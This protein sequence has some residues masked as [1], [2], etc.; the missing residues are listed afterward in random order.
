MR[1]AI[2]ILLWIT[3]CL[4]PPHV[5]AES[6][7]SAPE[8]AESAPEREPADQDTQEIL[9]KVGDIEFTQCLLNSHGRERQV[10]CAYLSVP[11][12]PAQPYAKTI[13]LF[14]ARLP[15]KR[16][17]KVQ[18]DPMLFLAGGPGQAASQGFLFADY[19][20]S[21]LNRTRDFYLVDQRGTGRS[22]PLSCPQTLAEQDGLLD[23]SDPELIKE[24]MR[25]CLGEITS[26]T[27]LYT[28]LNSI[29]DFERVRQALGA[30]QWNLLG[31]SYGTRVATEYMRAH[32]QHVR[33]VVLDSVVDPSAALGPDIG[34]HSQLALDAVI[35]RCAADPACQKALPNLAAELQSLL[36]R[37]ETNSVQ[38]AYEDFSTGKIKNTQLSKAHITMVIR[39][40]LYQPHSSALLP[41]IIHEAAH[42]KFYAP[43][44]R[45]TEQ[46]SEKLQ[47]SISLG[48]HN[49]VMCAE[50]IPFVKEPYPS[51]GY[52][53]DSVIKSMLS[54]CAVW[55]HATVA[56]EA[57]TALK[58]AIPTLL[59]SGEYD[60]I[61]PPANAEA[62]AQDL[63]NSAHFV[64]KGQAHSVS[65][66]GCAPFLIQQF[67]DNASVQGLNSNCLERISGAPLFINF[68]GPAP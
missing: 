24:S 40:F 13:E 57:K 31:V 49:S 68:N 50:D 9:S 43:L 21:G 45:L 62:A 18:S 51:D 64:L 3:C 39:M 14:I 55:P 65:G 2:R 32:P 48:L 4:A 60:P 56:Q 28:T 42:N 22:N 44:A 34:S 38:V 47:A 15:A 67:V 10:E 5:F 33:S 17:A 29:E 11:E 63:P 27:R 59:F 41:P 7:S 35:N 1:K 58:S 36:E 52:L 26:D 20:Y 54:I 53:G 6:S 23:Q 19:I 46:W 25:D 16:K 61:T 8:T 37:F 30:E 66:T 12:D